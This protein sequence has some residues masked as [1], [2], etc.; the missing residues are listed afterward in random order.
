MIH[1][2][3]KLEKKKNRFRC[4]GWAEKPTHLGYFFNAQAYAT[5]LYF[6]ILFYIWLKKIIKQII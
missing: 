4:T 6:F 1:P 2:F 3:K 5:R